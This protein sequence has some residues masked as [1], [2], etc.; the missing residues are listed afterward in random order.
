MEIRDCSPWVESNL[1]DQALWT[2]LCSRSEIANI[3]QR[4]FWNINTFVFRSDFL[5]PNKDDT[6][7]LARPSLRLYGCLRRLIIGIDLNPHDLDLMRR[8]ADSDMLKNVKHCT[9]QVDYLTGEYLNMKDEMDPPSI[10]TLASSAEDAVKR[11]LS[12]VNP[13]GS[14]LIRF[15]CPGTINFPFIMLRSNS[16]Y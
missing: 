7:Y 13:E 12:R 10:G 2:L 4:A 5:Y 6:T 15:R 16:F 8:I 14:D 9:I 11:W 3:A 1:F